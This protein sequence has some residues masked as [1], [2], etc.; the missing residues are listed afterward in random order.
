[1][2]LRSMIRLGPRRGLT[3]YRVAALYVAALIGFMAL[4]VLFPYSR[5]IDAIVLGWCCL[6]LAFRESAC[7]PSAE[8]WPWFV[9]SMGHARRRGILR[10]TAHWTGPPPAPRA[11]PPVGPLDGRL[12]TLR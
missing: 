4:L 12:R 3:P 2:D 10:R 9:L 6:F 8:G 11:R 7:T 5:T 1:M